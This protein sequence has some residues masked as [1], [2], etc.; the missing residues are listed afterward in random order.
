VTQ[1]FRKIRVGLPYLVDDIKDL[2]QY[3]SFSN[4]AEDDSSIESESDLEDVESEDEKIKNDSCIAKDKS[5]DLQS[6][7]NLDSQSNTK[8]Y[9]LNNDNNIIN[10]RR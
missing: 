10:E 7:E 5:N 4:I 6:T 3:K 2:E 9:L 1:D 8:K